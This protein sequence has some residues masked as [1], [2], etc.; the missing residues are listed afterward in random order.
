MIKRFG[1]T[2]GEF[3]AAGIRV[4]ASRGLTALETNTFRFHHGDPGVATMAYSTE[5]TKTHFGV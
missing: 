5:A 2:V 3:H 4:D 1:S